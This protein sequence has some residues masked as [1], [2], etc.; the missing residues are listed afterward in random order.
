M[1]EGLDDFLLSLKADHYSPETIYNYERD[2]LMFSQ[3]LSQEDK[4]I[5]HLSP[6]VLDR[7]KAYLSSKDRQTP[8]GDEG[9]RLSPTSVNRVI[10][11][12]RMYLKYLHR[13]GEDLPVS[14]D[15][16]TLVK[17]EKKHLRVPGLSDI[18]KLIEAPTKLEKN[19]KVAL[20]NRAALETLFATGMRI[21]ELLSLNRADLDG[22]GRIFIKGKG[23][24]ERF[25]Y[26]TSRAKKHLQAYLAVRDDQAPALFVPFR[27]P[28]AK[29]PDRRLSANYLQEKIKSYRERLNLGVPISA[30]T[31]RHAYATFLA[32]KGASLEAIRIL[33][34]HE[35]LSTTTRY[36]NASDKFAEK[37]HK[38]YHPLK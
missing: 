31:L 10:S 8:E 20:R 30:H 38:K 19:K 9:E 11:S 13:T 28:N 16:L 25:V 32:E 2:L 12:V 3:F 17:M 14:W 18:V 29:D 6:K 4:K 37:T 26:L 33:L 36:V 34:G 1:I 15:D 22:T 23:R 21:S 5:S 7:F 27:G 35:S 24:K